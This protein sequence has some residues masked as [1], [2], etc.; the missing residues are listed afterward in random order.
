VYGCATQQIKIHVR[1]SL[2]HYQKKLSETN[3]NAL[4]VIFFLIATGYIRSGVVVNTMRKIGT[5]G[6]TVMINEPE[7]LP[8]KISPGERLSRDLDIVV[9]VLHILLD[10]PTGQ[11]T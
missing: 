4:L 6:T 8:E 1:K 7:L 10:K 9:Q 2:F 3:R 5:G 11:S